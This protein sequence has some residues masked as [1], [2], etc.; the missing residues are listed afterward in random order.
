[1][2]VYFSDFIL[3][4]IQ[5]S[6]NS[7]DELLGIK[8]PEGCTNILV[9]REATVDGSTVGTYSSDGPPYGA[10]QAIPGEVFPLGTLTTIYEDKGHDTLK[11]YLDST[12]SRGNLSLYQYRVLF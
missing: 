6:S 12:S 11:N 2:V 10:V 8:K 9:G 5:K 1:M 3:G 7:K 4:S